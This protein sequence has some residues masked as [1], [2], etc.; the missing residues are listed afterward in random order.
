MRRRYRFFP[1]LCLFLSVSALYALPVRSITTVD[2]DFY[3]YNDTGIRFEEAC[4]LRF[5]NGMSG[6]VKAEW[7]DAPQGE[8]VKGI[9]GIVFPLFRYSY[10]ETSYGL[11]VENGS[12]LVHHLI[13]DLY[14][15]RST[16][17]LILSNRL[18]LSDRRST[19]LPALT[20][21]C[22]VAD[23]IAILGKYSSAFD[24]QSG[25]DHSFWGEF[26][27]ALGEKWDLI[28]GGTIGTYHAN[29]S[30]KQELEESFIGGLSFLPGKRFRFSYRFEY[31]FR[32][33]YELASHSL[34]ADVQF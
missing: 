1:A 11:E 16:Y 29:E 2:S 32:R 12:D 20:A 15:E 23:W 19:V 24:S 13:T 28:T 18:E 14:Y 17:Y 33:Q 21:R 25:F 30:D 10:M 27:W 7:Q 4:I 3:T 5:R 26:T 9:L 8:S 31:L 22:T 34:V 6:V